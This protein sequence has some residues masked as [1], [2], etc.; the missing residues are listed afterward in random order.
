[1]SQLADW[2]DETIPAMEQAIV[3]RAMRDIGMVEM[4]PGSNR[5]PRIDEYV[6]AVRSLVGSR[7]CAA[8]LAAWWRESD[9]AIPVADGGS[10]NAWMTWAIRQKIWSNDPLPGSAVVYGRNGAAA[11]IGVIVRISPVL[12]S[13]EANTSI[14]GELDVNGIAV[15]LKRVASVRVLGYVTPRAA[16]E[17]I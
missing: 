13:V 10:C 17:K 15:T 5:S 4:P 16:L 6:A 14:A 12:L 8:A 11:H 1:M 2:L 7:W 3:R 9:A